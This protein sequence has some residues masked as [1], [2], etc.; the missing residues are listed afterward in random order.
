[1]I[2]SISIKHIAH[3]SKDNVNI[4]SLTGLRTEME[5]AMSSVKS[6]GVVPMPYLAGRKKNGGP[7]RKLPHLTSALDRIEECF[8][9]KPSD[10]KF[11]NIV[12]LLVESIVVVILEL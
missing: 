10:S 3:F 12:V 9:L 1:M 5:S 11:R 8:I 6:L 7:V 2:A 4:E